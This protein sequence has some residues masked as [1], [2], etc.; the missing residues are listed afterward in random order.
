MGD[1]TCKALR[2]D[3]ETG[4]ALPTPEMLGVL[5]DLADRMYA[6]DGIGEDVPSSLI[7]RDKTRRSQGQS[8]AHSSD[9]VRAA[10]VE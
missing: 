7:S 9:D 8:A 6:L 3:V 1:L 4:E 10:L 5:V 2:R